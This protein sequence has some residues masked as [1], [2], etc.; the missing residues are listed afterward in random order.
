MLSFIVACTSSAPI[1]RPKLLILRHAEYEQNL[2]FMAFRPITR[3]ICSVYPWKTDL[4]Q[5]YPMKISYR[6]FY[7]AI[8]LC[9]CSASTLLI[10]GLNKSDGDY[11][12]ALNYVGLL[13]LLM[14]RLLNSRNLPF[15][16]TQIS[17]HQ[18]VNVSMCQHSHAPLETQQA[19]H[20][21][22]TF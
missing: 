17:P 12:N 13:M 1:S 18:L 3:K 6:R 16:V 8:W 14:L 10:R 9:H 2:S 20:Y 7:F 4:H 19:D 21:S 5:S 15:S 22:S 11:T